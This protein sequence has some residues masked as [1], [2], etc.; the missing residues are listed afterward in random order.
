MLKREGCAQAAGVG[1]YLASRRGTLEV[2]VAG[3]F[4]PWLEWLR[5]VAMA[6]KCGGHTTWVHLAN[7]RRQ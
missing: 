6:L 2:L 5:Q 3:C 4:L 7:G 1:K